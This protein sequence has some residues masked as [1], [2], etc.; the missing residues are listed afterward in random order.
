MEINIFQSSRELSKAAAEFFVKTAAESINKRGK[1]SVVLSG[2][3]TPRGMFEHLAAYPEHDKV[4]WDKIY[5]FWGDER[6]VGLEDPANNAYNAINLFL[7]K[8]PIIPGHI[9]RIESELAPADAAKQYE[10]ILRKYFGNQSPSFDLVFLGLGE[11]GHTASL[12]PGTP[13][14]RETEHWVRAVYVDELNAYR[15]TLTPVLINQAENIVFLVSGKEKA[16]VLQRVIEGEYDPEHL[17][18]QLIKPVDGELY[19]FCDKD[20]AKLIEIK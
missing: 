8:V 17:P 10:A 6:C 7:I 11:N 19:W 9:H 5:V 18:A 3:S 1:F 2:G 20:A 14:L 15:I 16:S 12:F 13:V 4:A